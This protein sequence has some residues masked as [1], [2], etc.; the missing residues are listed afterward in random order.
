VYQGVEKCM[1][2]KNFSWGWVLGIA[3]VSADICS[4]IFTSNCVLAQITPDTSL[5]N[6]TQ[7]NT[8]GNTTNITGGT[9]AGTNLFHSFQEFSVLKGNT[10]FFN[11][12]V[13]IQNIIS[14]VT[15]GSISNVDGL[16][17]ANGT[18]NL[19]LLNPNGIVFGSN[20]R[21][22]I[23]GSFIG[24]TAN[25]IKFADGTE[26]KANP[27]N[28]SPLLTISVPL[29]LQFGTDP[30]PINY[31]SDI[32]DP[33]NQNNPGLEVREGKTLALVGGN[34]LLDGA[35]L[36]APAG[37]VEIVAVGSNGSVSLRGCL[38]SREC[39]KKALSV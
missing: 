26:F 17:R 14:R 11:N 39:C 22:D 16:I 38:K 31:Q 27:H 20:A 13:D 23:G 4:H 10:A 24:S 30:K 9:Q 12:T 37:R 28:T 34:I 25:S 5:P 21:L 6:P 29:G 19:F 36:K 1:H 32:S 33:I 18:A 2:T 8:V 35:I 15:G 7:V 3:I